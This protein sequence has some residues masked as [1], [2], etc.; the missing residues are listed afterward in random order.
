MKC[1]L[2]ATSHLFL[3]RCAVLQVGGII[4]AG[5]V[6]R[7]QGRLFVALF[8]RL[9]VAVRR[10]VH[11][12]VRRTVS[13]PIC[14]ALRCHIIHEQ[15]ARLAGASSPLGEGSTGTTVR[16]REGGIGCQFFVLVRI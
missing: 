1:A 9:F 15:M 12:A 10:A 5:G 8:V 13:L 6:A 14:Y 2:S 4:L 16:A 7:F 3:L 11:C